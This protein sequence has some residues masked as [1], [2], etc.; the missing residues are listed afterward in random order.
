MKIEAGKY[1][2]TRDGQKVGPMLENEGN[3]FWPWTDSPNTNDGKGNAWSVFGQGCYC[4]PQAVECADLD[5][6]AEWTESPVREVTRKEIVPGVYGRVKVFRE[7]NGEALLCLV[8]RDGSEVSTS[9]HWMNCAELT[10]AIDTLTQIRDAMQDR[11][12]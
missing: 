1:Y 2:R 7:E 8:F 10:A 5:I 12:K 11:R 4:K 3:S 9:A 6:I